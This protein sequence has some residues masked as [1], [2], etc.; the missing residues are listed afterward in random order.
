MPTAKR[1]SK[2]LPVRAGPGCAVGVCDPQRIQG[3][4]EPAPEGTYD[5]VTLKGPG[6]FLSANVTKQGGP[7]GLTFV[8][9]EIDNRNVVDFSFAA[10]SNVGL[11]APNPYGLQL[12]SGNGVESFAIG[13]LFPL[14]FK[15]SLKL[16]VVV[17]ESGVVQILANVIFGSSG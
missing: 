14:T 9:L 7:T 2:T 4:E 16:S 17:N 12:L 8:Q 1:A 10:A 15:K 11:T 6:L 5:L 3:L 13:W